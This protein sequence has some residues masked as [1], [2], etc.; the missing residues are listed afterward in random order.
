MF[1]VLIFYC[2]WEDKVPGEKIQTMRVW[3]FHNNQPRVT[4]EQYMKKTVH[5]RNNLV[6]TDGVQ[7][8]IMQYPKIFTPGLVCPEM[9]EDTPEWL[10]YKVSF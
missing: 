10:G 6:K 7:G 5:D 8:I 1:Y 9:M 4:L 2:S 3:L